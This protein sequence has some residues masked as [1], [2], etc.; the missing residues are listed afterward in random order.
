MLMKIKNVTVP[1]PVRYVTVKLLFRD[2]ATVTLPGGFASNRTARSSDRYP[3][4]NTG[5]V[6]APVV[7]DL[8]APS[9]V[10]IRSSDTISRQHKQLESFRYQSL[11]TLPLVQAVSGDDTASSAST[12]TETTTSAQ[13]QD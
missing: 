4:Q 12:N 7:S 11:S 9:L 10:V 6:P 13:P 8:R 5:N 1:V 2:D 3:R